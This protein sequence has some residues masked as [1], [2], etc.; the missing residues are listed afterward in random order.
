MPNEDYLKQLAKSFGSSRAERVF[1]FVRALVS[2]GVPGDLV[3]LFVEQ[4]RSLLPPDGDAN[5]VLVNLQRFLDA[6]RST[7]VLAQP[8]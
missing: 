7:T 6:S 2:L 8:V 5:R 4:L 3:E 1:E